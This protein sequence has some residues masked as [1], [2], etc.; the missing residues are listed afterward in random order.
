MKTNWTG[1]SVA[2]KGSETRRKF[3]KLAWSIPL[4]LDISLDRTDGP[5]RA[6]YSSTL[7]SDSFWFC[8]IRKRSKTAFLR[9]EFSRT[10]LPESGN[11]SRLSGGL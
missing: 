10:S 8:L 3:E 4:I 1:S 11:I 2:Y 9:V 5:L 7:T 6:Y